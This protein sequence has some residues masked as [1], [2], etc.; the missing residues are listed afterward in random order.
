MQRG[1]DARSGLSYDLGS[2]TRSKCV[3]HCVVNMKKIK[4]LGARDF[5]HFYCQRQSVV[6]TGKQGVVRKFDSMEMKTLL[7]QVESYRLGVT[8]EVNFVTAPSQLRTECCRQN[9]TSAD[10]W[11]TCNPD[12][13][14][15]R[16]HHNS[17]YALSKSRSE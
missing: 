13:E 8:K 15:P 10:Q 4:L 17:V 3:R 9:A 6:G 1:D 7:W 11:K 12:F 14:R 5:C 2:Q 16:S